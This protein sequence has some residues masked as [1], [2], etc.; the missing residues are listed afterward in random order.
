[1]AS[2]NSLVLLTQ[3]KVRKVVVV[4]M[5]VVVVVRGALPLG[6]LRLPV[7]AQDS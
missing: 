1:M 7:P 5:V 3:V 4:M 2:P 6:V